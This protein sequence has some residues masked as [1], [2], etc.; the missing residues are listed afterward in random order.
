[1]LTFRLFLVFL[2]TVFTCGLLLSAEIEGPPIVTQGDPPTVEVNLSPSPG[3]TIKSVT[4]KSSDVPLPVEFKPFRENVE[5]KVSIAFLIDVSAPAPRASQIKASIA[6]VKNLLLAH[7]ENFY[8]YG[9]YALG[10]EQLVE[11]APVGTVSGRAVQMLESYKP[12]GQTTQGYKLTVQAIE[13]L[14]DRPAQRK[15]LV[16]LSDGKFE[17]TAFGHGDVVEKAN[18]EEVRLFGIGYAANEDQSRFLQTLERMAVETDGLYVQTSYGTWAL[19][20]NFVDRFFG[21]LEGGGIVRV[22]LAELEVGEK[23]NIELEI[24]DGEGVFRKTNFEIEL[25]APPESEEKDEKKDEEDDSKAKGD[26]KDKEKSESAEEA[27]EAVDSLLTWYVV[28]GVAA[29]VLLIAIVAMLLPK[30]K[31]SAAGGA[32]SPQAPPIAFLEMLDA[33]ST[34]HPIRISNFRLGRGRDNDLVLQNDSV[35]SNHCVI[36]Q[37]RDGEWTIVDLKSGNGIF[38]NDQRVEE[39]TLREGD[40]IEL[41]EVKMRFYEAA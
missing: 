4:A 27:K 13:K 19:P 6:T 14:R 21:M 17:D 34:R 1:M 20:E 39:A 23:H 32:S 18:E 3:E 41:G 9:I 7:P 2:T 24:K 36:K 12:S 35:S 30:K 25:A 26:S 31:H 37:S 8:E 33:Q 29:L 38:V 28:G 15:A 10:K 22:D 5:A 16:V 11:I 40:L